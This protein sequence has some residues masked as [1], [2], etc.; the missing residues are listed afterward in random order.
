M[1]IGE[2]EE[3]L[4]RYYAGRTTE[5]QEEVLREY[6]INEEVPE[7]FLT[8]KGLFLSFGEAIHTEV[9]SGLEEKLARMI[10]EKAEAGKHFMAI[11]RSRVSW[12]WIGSIA[13]SVVILFGLG[14]AL[15]NTNWG[16]RPDDTFTDP[17]EA[18][19]IIQATLIEVSCNLNDGMAQ[20]V[21]AK[22]EA[23][24][25]NEEIIQEIQ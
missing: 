12:K 2:I 23:N 13:A 8:D 7:R 24:V 17:Q 1:K 3:L 20:L 25:I 22:Q 14:F 10:D 15:T 6:F 21:E 5:K 19:R 4:D 16:D 18:Y 11:N 9:P